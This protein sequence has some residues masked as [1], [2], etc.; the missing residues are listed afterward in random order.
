MSLLGKGAMVIWHDIVA[1]CETGYNEWHSK[2]HMLERVGVPGF[3]RGQRGRVVGE[4][5]HY[6]NLYEVETLATLTSQPYLDR[7]NDPTPWTRKAMSYFVGGNRTLCQVVTS[8]GNGICGHVLTLQLSAADGSGDGLAAWLSAA[9]PELVKRP[10]VLSAHYL[11]GDDAASRV[12]TEEKRLKA[13]RDEVADRVVLVGACDAA[14][15]AEV[16]ENV[17]A[18]QQLIAQGAAEQQASAVYQLVHC[19]A[20]ADLE[21]V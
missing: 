14:V 20:E 12:Q 21:A 18:P 6:L 4:G 2:E 13:T 19:I 3:H 16:R 15:L 17:L 8:V 10:G 11:E 5:P 9:M 7:L 1:G